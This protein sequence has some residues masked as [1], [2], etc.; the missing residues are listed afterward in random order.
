MRVSYPSPWEYTQPSADIETLLQ[1]DERDVHD[2]M[3]GTVSFS[4]SEA[5]N[6]DKVIVVLSSFH[7]F[8][9]FL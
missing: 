3:V 5:A 2:R 9:R 7:W 1:L 8:V 6:L 4:E